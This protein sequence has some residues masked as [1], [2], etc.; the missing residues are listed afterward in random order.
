MAHE[1]K[2][3][4]IQLVQRLWMVYK[5]HDPVVFIVG[6]NTDHDQF[7]QSRADS[8]ASL[9]REKESRVHCR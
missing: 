9:Y 2:F 7:K 3:D 4:A 6:T 5:S 8:R 1:P